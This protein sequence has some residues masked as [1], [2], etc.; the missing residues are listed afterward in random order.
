MSSEAVLLTV[1]AVKKFEV[2]VVY[3]FNFY[4]FYLKS[5]KCQDYIASV[6][7]RLINMDQLME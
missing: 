2:F 3:I 6:A 5:R 1:T 7:G 4:G